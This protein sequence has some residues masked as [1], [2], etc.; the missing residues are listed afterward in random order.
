MMNAFDLQHYF[1]DL[2][3][4]KDKDFIK[5]FVAKYKNKHTDHFYTNQNQDGKFDNLESL[6]KLIESNNTEILE[7]SIEFSTQKALDEALFLTKGD[8]LEIIKILVSKGARFMVQDT[9]SSS[10]RIVLEPLTAM[11]KFLFEE[12]RKKSK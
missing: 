8:Q 9:Y 11:V 7:Y 4:N 5:D 12:V 2:I 6:K 3:E 1:T 10:N